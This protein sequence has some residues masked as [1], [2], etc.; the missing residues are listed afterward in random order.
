MALP[1][2]VATPRMDLGLPATTLTSEGQKKETSDTFS[3]QQIK[4]SLEDIIEAKTQF[5]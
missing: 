1:V 3:I 2:P 5:I 4:C